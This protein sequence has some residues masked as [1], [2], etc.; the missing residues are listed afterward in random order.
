MFAVSRIAVEINKE[1]DNAKK[2]YDYI[3]TKF[4]SSQLYLRNNEQVKAKSKLPNAN[5]SHLEKL[6]R[7]YAI[8]Q[9]EDDENG[10]NGLGDGKNKNPTEMLASKEQALA[11]LKP[12][13]F[14]VGAMLKVLENQLPPLPEQI[15]VKQEMPPPYPA[16]F[17]DWDKIVI[18]QQPPPEKADKK[19][20]QKPQAK[21][22]QL[23]K[24]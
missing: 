5:K 21:K 14:N 1:V 7:Y 13:Q 12:L 6:R 23:K 20:N 24:G 19:G 10:E 8:T 17:K 4:F 15:Q 18:G 16:K 22:T 2:V 11:N 3:L 9:E